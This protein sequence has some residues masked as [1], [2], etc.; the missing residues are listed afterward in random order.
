MDGSFHRARPSDAAK[1]D[2]LFLGGRLRRPQHRGGLHAGPRPRRGH[3]GGCRASN[4]GDRRFAHAAPRF[5]LHALPTP[6]SSASSLAGRSFGLVGQAPAFLLAPFPTRLRRRPRGS[7][8]IGR[9]ALP[10]RT[11][12]C[13]GGVVVGFVHRDGLLGVGRYSGNAVPGRHTA[14]DAATPGASRAKHRLLRRTFPPVS[15]S[16]PFPGLVQRL[17]ALC[18]VSLSLFF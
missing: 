5:A 10:N 15:P 1:S 13:H 3:E 7:H 17:F 9:A 18:S 14:Q 16:R 4:D 8:S 11:C 2:D 12:P 6:P